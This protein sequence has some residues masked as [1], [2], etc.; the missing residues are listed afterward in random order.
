MQIIEDAS[1]IKLTQDDVL[2]IKFLGEFRLQ[3]GDTAVTGI[4]TPAHQSLLAY[5]I[6]NRDKMHTRRQLA[7]QFWPDSTESQARTN[8]RKAIYAL[9]HNLP[10]PERFLCLEKQSIQWFPDGPFELDVTN[11]KQFLSDGNWESPSNSLDTLDN[12]DAGLSIEDL[13][14]AISCYRGDLL[15]D[16]YDDWV[17]TTR[18]QLRRCYLT[19]L[20]Q[21]IVK[22][23]KERQYDEAIAY[24]RRHLREDP[25]YEST[26]RRLMRLHA[27]DGNVAGALRVYHLCMSTLQRELSVTPGRAT[28][29][30]YER[31]LQLDAPQQITIPDRIPFVARE[32]VWERLQTIWQQVV[33]GS[34]QV[35]LLKGEAGI[36]KTRL[37]EELLDW[38]R[39]QG[40]TT[41]TAVCYAGEGK[42][43]FS[44]IADWLRSDTLQ[45]CLERVAGKWLVEC[46]RL[47][48]ELLAKYPELPSPTPLSEGWQRQHFFASVAQ[49]ILTAPQPLLLFIDDLQW[50]D[51]D[52]LEWLHFFLRF[53]SEA[54]FLLLGSVRTEDVLAAHPFIE[55]QQNLK[56]ES[57][58]TEIKL[59]RFDLEATQHLAEQIVHPPLIPEQTACLFAE[60]EGVPLFIVEMARAG[61]N[62][63]V[64]DEKNEALLPMQTAVQIPAKV[65]TIIEA[66]LAQ[67]APQARELMDIAAVIGRSFQFDLLVQVSDWDEESVVRGLDEL[68]HRR[69]VREYGIDA[70][71]FSHDKIR[72]VAYQSISPIRKRYLH[73]SLAQILETSRGEKIGF[74]SGQIA[75]H[76]QQSGQYQKAVDYYQQAAKEA[77][78]VGANKESVAYLQQAIDLFSNIEVESQQ[79]TD[80]YDSL[81]ESFKTLGFFKEAEEVLIEAL[82]STSQDRSL[83][84]LYLSLAGAQGMQSRFNQAFLSLANAEKILQR[85]PENELGRW[86]HE[87][88]KISLKYLDLYYF[89][90]KIEEM[91]RLSEDIQ[92]DIAQYGTLE[93]KVHFLRNITRSRFTKERYVLSDETI[94]HAEEVYAVAQESGAKDTVANCRY[95]LALAYLWYGWRG[96]L[97][98]AELLLHET[99]NLAVEMG[100][101]H[102]RARCL[103]FLVLLYRRLGRV[104]RVLEMLPEALSSAQYC[105]FLT[106]IATIEGNKAWLKWKDDDLPSAKIHGMRALEIWESLPKVVSFKWIALWPLLEITM[107]WDE[108]EETFT[109]AKSLLDPKQS[110]LPAEITAVLQ[111]AIT[112]YENDQP[113]V[114][115]NEFQRSLE[116][117]KTYN[118]I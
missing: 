1:A 75:F 66:R 71:D 57:Y 102:L 104:E 44:P 94:A 69:I 67:L 42:L 30:A 19:S 47:V 39:R 22:L 76:Y 23:E 8:L 117:A 89:S 56:Q 90:G 106:Y 100:N 65:Q 77:G 84:Q 37:A 108:T 80:I 14:E 92:Q 10:Q 36:G 95:D 82:E 34:S 70:Y 54:R 61:L 53:D 38:A 32:N 27:L 87:Q 9:R 24:A 58:L 16:L 49:T 12:L 91:I 114:A 99:M 88:I 98:K 116:L 113:D 118:Y 72:Q 20:D 51:Q 50:S 7:F 43:P 31:L 101:V 2:Q 4:T 112:A 46:T 86:G 28:Q 17:L 79:K 13:K 111:H 68:W 85:L 18:E 11:F 52:T 60:T 63:L 15:P 105:N 55:W 3:L 103:N 62:Y 25:L 35:A 83:I 59:H 21:L 6:L 109:H 29:E 45:P 93:Q 5:L 74:H 33:K 48:P 26:Y 81:G 110:S 97:R 73:S 40:I 107:A 64:C 115:L 96:N 41:L 78:G